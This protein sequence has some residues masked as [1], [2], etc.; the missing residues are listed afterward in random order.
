MRRTEVAL[1]VV[2]VISTL[3]I[4]IPADGETQQESLIC[5]KCGEVITGSYFETY[6]FYYHSSCFVC[7][8]CSRQIKGSYTTYQGEEY[9]TDC[10]E[11]SVAKRCSLCGGIIQGEYLFDFWGNA[12]HLTHQ[13]ETHA[14]EYCGRFIGP[15]T[16]GGGTRYSDGRY[17]CDIC[18]ESAVTTQNEAMRVMAEVA[19]HMRRFGMDVNLGEVDLHIVGLQEMQKKS[20]KGSYRLTGFTD[21]EETKNLFGIA[22]SRRIDVH[23]L[24]GMPR[25]DVVSTLA[26]ELAHVWQFTAGR[27]N[28]DQAFSE[29]SCNYA[30]YL[31]L[32]VY[33]EE[34]AAYVVA[35][36]TS[37]ENVTYGEGFRR[38]RR[39]AEKEGIDTWLERLRK[40][41]TL[42]EGY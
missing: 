16:T 5:K 42:P 14:C 28:N 35:N 24:Y 26:H 34:A 29:G 13:K 22:T 1:I 38:V 36:L 8:Y 10:F 21:F 4:A 33:R 11:D 30:A 20:G 41:N 31:V 7:A 25:V 6:G 2:A 17:I 27:L 39:Y 19:R 32:R 23:L 12:Y 15:L 3:A 40:K 9:H 37:D 18:R